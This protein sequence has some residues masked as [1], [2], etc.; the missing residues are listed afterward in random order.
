MSVATI[1]LLVVWLVWLAS[2]LVGWILETRRRKRKPEKD[3][4]AQKPADRIIWGESCFA[5]YSNANGEQPWLV[6]KYDSGW[7]FF[8][9]NEADAKEL[10]RRLDERGGK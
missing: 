5:E 4:D 9:T 7:G 10:M 3:P 2:L 1:L 8:L 6:Q